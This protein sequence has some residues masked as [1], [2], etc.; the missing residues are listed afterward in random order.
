MFPRLDIDN[1]H[2]TL[3]E[4][5]LRG[6]AHVVTTWDSL[7]GVSNVSMEDQL[8]VAGALIRSGWTGSG[9]NA[10][11]ADGELVSAG[12]WAAPTQANA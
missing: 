1:M 7:T 5:D 10:S 2:W 6:G 4:H 3:H 8:A 9:A 12:L 11:Q